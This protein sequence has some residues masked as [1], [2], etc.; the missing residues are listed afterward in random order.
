MSLLLQEG[1]FT[2]HPFEVL[3]GLEAIQKGTISLFE[4]AVSAKKLVYR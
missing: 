1:K 3:G 2:A 4:N